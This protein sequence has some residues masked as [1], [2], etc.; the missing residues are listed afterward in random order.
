MATGNEWSFKD[1]VI[2]RGGGSPAFSKTEFWQIRLRT[3]LHNVG[4]QARVY[5]STADGFFLINVFRFFGD[6]PIDDVP[7]IIHRR[8]LEINQL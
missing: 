6:K 2:G 8:H 1:D 5:P 3:T 7:E 4:V